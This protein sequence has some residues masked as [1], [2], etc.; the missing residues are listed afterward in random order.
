VAKADNHEEVS[1]ILL[2][3]A[4]CFLGIGGAGAGPVLAVVHQN[5]IGCR[6]LGDEPPLPAGQRAT[7]PVMSA[8]V[9]GLGVSA[10]F[11]PCHVDESRGASSLPEAPILDL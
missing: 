8:A 11:G 1:R 6:R 10:F 3:T 9:L 5:A 7:I 4:I 2:A